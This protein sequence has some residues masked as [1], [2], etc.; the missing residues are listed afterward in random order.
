[1]RP[2]AALVFLLVP[3]L[4]LADADGDGFDAP[5]DCD[6]TNALVYPGA[7]EIPADGIDRNCDGLEACYLDADGDHYG[8][9]GVVST[10]DFTCTAPGLSTNTADCNDGTSRV[11]PGAP[12]VP[13]NG[14]DEN[15]DGFELCYL[16]ADGDHYGRNIVGSSDDLTCTASGFSNNNDDCDDTDEQ[17]HPGAAEIPDQ[18]DNDCDGTPDEG[19]VNVDDDL[20][21]LTES[22]GDCNDANADVHPNAT[23]V[24]NSVDDD[25]SGVVDDNIPAQTWFADLD[26]DGFG[27]ATGVQFDADC[28]PSGPWVLVG[29]DCDDDRGDVSPT[30]PEL[31]N[32]VDDDCDG[33]LADDAAVC[34]EDADSDGVVDAVDLCPTVPDPGQEDRDG[35]GVGDA[36]DNCPLAG[37]SPDQ[38]NTDVDTLGDVCDNCPFLTN[39]DQ[40]DVDLDGLGDACDNCPDEPNP[41]QADVDEDGVG[42]ACPVVDTAGDTAADSD[43]DVVLQPISGCRGLGGAYAFFPLLLMPAAWRRRSAQ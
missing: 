10:A 41:D 30:A 13:G 40:D 6:D 28:P 39:E 12:E 2:L 9:S 37:T 14:V 18:A 26:G 31:C 42:D 5:D 23:E 16:D 19:T 43:T 24:C 29:G 34:P 33:S 38:Q 32:G 11:H 4:A 25:C 1:M 27:D 22:G 3:S 15:C 20:D 8:R 21:G 17:T 35:D 7:P 36:C